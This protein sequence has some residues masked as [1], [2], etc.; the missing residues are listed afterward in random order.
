MRPFRNYQKMHSCPSVPQ[1]TQT[2]MAYDAAAIIM[3]IDC[4]NTTK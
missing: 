3:P 2:T 1:P 4:Y